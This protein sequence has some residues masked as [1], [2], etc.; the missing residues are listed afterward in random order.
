MPGLATILNVVLAVPFVVVLL[1][2][3]AAAGDGDAALDN[4]TTI[5][6]G[7]AVWLVSVAII[8]GVYKERMEKFSESLKADRDARKERDAEH[9]KQIEKIVEKIHALELQS[10]HDG[11]EKAI[12]QL[13]A[14][15]VDAVQ[16]MADS[17]SRTSERLEDR[18]RRV[19]QSQSEVGP[20]MNEMLR[21]T[22][23]HQMLEQRVSMIEQSIQ[24]G[25]GGQ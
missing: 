14:S 18:L 20:A 8:I 4:S 9:S 16:R 21:A 7:A 12:A 11:V 25:Q 1:A 23:S 24:R 10:N 22:G 3:P 15:M 13:G 17:M 5:T 19:E 6:I 2:S